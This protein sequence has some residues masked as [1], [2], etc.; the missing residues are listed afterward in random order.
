M[1]K[2][3]LKKIHKNAAILVAI[4]PI[5]AFSL[6]IFLKFNPVWVIQHLGSAGAT[7][8]NYIDS[9]KLVHTAN[10]TIAIVFI[11]SCACMFA[12]SPDINIS[13]RN[14][15]M[16]DDISVLKNPNNPNH[17]ASTFIIQIDTDYRG[18]I[19]YKIIEILGGIIINVKTPGWAEP[20]L[21]NTPWDNSDY[22]KD[23]F[24][25]LVQIDITKALSSN[26][27]DYKGEIFVGVDIITNITS[28]NES[29]IEV[30]VLS[31]SDKKIKSA[32][33]NFIIN[34]IL[35]IKYKKHKIRVDY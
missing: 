4:S 18:W 8:Y 15:A 23:N 9:N 21:N 27:E 32:I 20:T 19:W 34:N 13:I 29:P 31:R 28:F 26:L 22:A 7:F 33:L 3:C 17:K 30:N 11:N 24:T 5:L 25:N 6:L 35:S 1:L 2:K 16:K 14:R 10:Y 12:F